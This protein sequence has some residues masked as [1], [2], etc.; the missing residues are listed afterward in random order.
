[1]LVCMVLG[2]IQR[3]LSHAFCAA[4][5]AQKSSPARVPRAEQRIMSPQLPLQP[6][7]PMLTKHL[8]SREF[9]SVTELRGSPLIVHRRRGSESSV[10]PLRLGGLP[11]PSPRS[12]SSDAVMSQQAYA[13]L[14]HARA[15]VRQ[16][17]LDQKVQRQLAQ[18]QARKPALNRCVGTA[19]RVPPG[20]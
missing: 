8:P 12:R 16:E 9:G 11:A 4:T 15:A 10:P 1:M 17:K 18:E 13:D 7:F 3:W 19:G 20:A 2:S 5:I 14:M 6:P